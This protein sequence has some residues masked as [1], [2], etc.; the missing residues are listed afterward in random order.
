MRREALKRIFDAAQACDAVAS[1][2][3]GRNA[4]DLH[5]DAMLRSAVERQFEILG[6]ALKQAESYE[7][8]LAETIPD[9]RRIV[10][11]RNRLIH[12]YDVVDQDLL[13]ATAQEKLKP[14][15]LVLRQLLS[16][17]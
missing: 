5:S 12:G 6:E 17:G 3:A 14:L 13:W 8:G 1:F 10:G 16:E 15:G 11:L 9:L 7:P 4:S 2:L